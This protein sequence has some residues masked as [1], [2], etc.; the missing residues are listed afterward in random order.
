MLNNTECKIYFDY[1]KLFK[2]T[3]CKSASVVTNT[4]IEIY[5]QFN[6]IQSQE[7]NFNN[8]IL[9]SLEENGYF[10]NISFQAV[11]QRIFKIEFKN[12]LFKYT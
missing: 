7:I 11:V 4:Q 2:T 9:D 1:K 5:S 12:N 10:G 8:S 3:K 6:I